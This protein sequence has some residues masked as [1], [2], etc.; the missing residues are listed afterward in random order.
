[1][2]LF[3]ID[4]NGPFFRGYGKEMVNWSHIPFSNLERDGAVDEERW[5]AV[6]AEFDA[7]VDRVAE[8]GY[9]AITVDDLAHLTIHEEYPE[10]LKE[11]LRDY[12]RR[13][14]ELFRRARA[15]GCRVFVNSDIC[16]TH[17]ALRDRR[18][19][20]LLTEATAQAGSLPIDGIILRVGEESGVDVEE[21]FRSRLTLRS[22]EGLRRLLTR[23]LPLCEEQGLL[24]ILRTWTVGAYRLGDL[25]WN[26]RT[27]GRA[28]EG[29]E[30]E[31]L[32]LSMKYG[33]SDFYREMELNP[34]FFATP[35]KKVIE[36]QTRR[37]YELFGQ[38]PY[39]VGWQ[40]EEYV[41]RLAEAENV[42]GALVWCQTGGWGPWHDRTFLE[43]S[44]PWNDLNT[45]ATRR[46]LGGASAEEAAEEAMPGMLPFLRKYREVSGT[47]LD[48][49]EARGAYFRRARVPPL[50]WLRWN[51]VVLHPLLRALHCKVAPVE[52]D[53]EGLRRAGEGVKGLDFI[54]ETLRVLAAC[55]NALSGEEEGLDAAIAA[56]QTRYPGALHFHVSRTRAR[57]ARRLLPL[58]LRKEARYRRADHLFLSPPVTMLSRQLFKLVG[59][60]RCLDEQSMRP[61]TLFR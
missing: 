33:Q 23:L 7:F 39:Y 28:L 12:R 51:N 9:N 46:I 38:L 29:V 45:I 35:R 36:L 26:P 6:A 50:L 41:R 16:Y 15:K 48:V 13:F 59:R 52:P 56:Y 47:V 25:I 5:G 27:L 10:Q 2:E 14:A 49:G 60:P 22:P 18:A 20:R 58:L 37:E 1:M 54:I 43:E 4:A 3:L 42:V 32:I 31:A 11:R 57:I 19:E 55:R 21:E 17:P 24:C 44:S 34:L 40:Y 30:S 8:I 53:L 61:E